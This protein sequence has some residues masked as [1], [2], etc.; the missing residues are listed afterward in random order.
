MKNHANATTLL[1]DGNY[2][3]NILGGKLLAGSIVAA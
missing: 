2:I 1:Q 3:L